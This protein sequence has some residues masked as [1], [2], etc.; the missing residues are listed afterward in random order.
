M[1]N[2]TTISCDFHAFLNLVF[3]AKHQLLRLEPWALINSTVKNAL[4]TSSVWDKEVKIVPLTNDEIDS[5]KNQG[6]INSASSDEWF[7]LF[8]F[9]MW[10]EWNRQHTL[11]KIHEAEVRL[12]RLEK[13]TRIRENIHNATKLCTILYAKAYDSP[14]KAAEF[15]Q[16]IA[17][18]MP[19][20]AASLKLTPETLE[21]LKECAPSEFKLLFQV[22]TNPQQ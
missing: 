22:T 4:Q 10:E 16:N 21:Y 12:A 3:E 11:L 7:K 2:S 6:L 9:F 13:Q 18:G 5:L 1:T 20:V 8:R 19:Q 14:L 17:W 15:I